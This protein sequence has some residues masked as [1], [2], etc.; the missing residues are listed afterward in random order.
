MCNMYNK[1]LTC[2]YDLLTETPAISK[3]ILC[4][5]GTE[6]IEVKN[7]EDRNDT[8][9]IEGEN[10]EGRNA[11]EG[12]EDENVEG[13]NGT[14]VIEDK[15]IKGFNDTEEIKVENT[16]GRNGSAEIVGEDTEG[17]NTTEKIEGE[18]RGG[19]SVTEEGG[20][21]NIEGIECQVV[22]QCRTGFGCKR[23]VNTTSIPDDLVHVEAHGTLCFNVFQYKRLGGTSYKVEPDSKRRR[24]G[25]SI[26]SFNA[27][28]KCS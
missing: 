4:R 3:L 13:R 1:C 15:I 26:Q 10:I 28:P 22:M 9:E 2:T 19:R 25:F 27:N 23:L 21:E 12:I 8:E 11:T 24:L 20:G 18:N 7:I 5:N 14:E 16:E 6:K 17:G